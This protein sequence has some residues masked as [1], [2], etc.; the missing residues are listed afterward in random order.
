MGQQ[1]NE[2]RA[3]ELHCPKCG[4]CQPVRER[5]SATPGSR[6]IELLCFRCATV[7]GQHAVIDH[8]LTGKLTKLFSKL[9]K[10]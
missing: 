10:K 2:F 7:V 6:T 3:A 8:S 5:P 4:T 1:F 9:V